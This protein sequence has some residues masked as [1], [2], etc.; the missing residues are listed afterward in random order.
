MKAVAFSGGVDSTALLRRAVTEGGA[1]QLLALHVHHGLQ[2][3]AD[4]FAAHCVDVCAR[5]GVR[6]QVLRLALTVPLGESVEAVARTA[7]Y[8]ALAQAARQAGAQAV[9]LG[10]HADDQAETLL[11]ALSRGAGLPGLAAMPAS[12]EREGMR[13]ER[14]LLAVPRQV[15]VDEVLAAGLTWVDDPS[16]ADEQRTRNRIRH[17]VMPTLEAAFPQFRDTFARSARHAAQAQRLLDDLAR[18]DWAAGHGD[19]SHLQALGDER[20]ANAL[21][22]WLRRDHQAAPTEAQLLALVQQVKAASTRGHRIE[23]RVAD[24]LVTRGPQPDGPQL[25]FVPSGT[26]Q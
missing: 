11:L 2:P 22:G 7:R 15:L 9:L 20:L 17:R 10:H 13:F 25:R 26:G 4:G 18:L 5:L 16:N 1:Q 24:G 14:P 23:L 3:T 6:L 21:R 12:F 8:A 19:L